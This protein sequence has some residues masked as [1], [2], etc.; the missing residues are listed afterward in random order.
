[1]RTTV[2]YLDAVKARLDLPSDYAIAKVLG[3]TRAAVS[4]Y[5]N[6]HGVFDDEVCFAVAEILDIN[7]LEVIVAAQSERAKNDD[8]KAKWESYWENFSA[9]FRSPVFP[10]D[11]RQLRLFAQ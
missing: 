2:E 10:A 8:S 11:A 1:M 6:G 5:R 4:R 7:P 3:I 9:N